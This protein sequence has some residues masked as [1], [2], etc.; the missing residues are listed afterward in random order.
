[1]KWV[2]FLAYIAQPRISKN[3]K[4]ESNQKK[5]FPDKSGNPESL[6]ISLQFESSATDIHTV[7]KHSLRMFY[8]LFYLRACV[9]SHL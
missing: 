2:T 1:M 4:L 5:T 9:S 3:Q 7:G 6:K 8:W